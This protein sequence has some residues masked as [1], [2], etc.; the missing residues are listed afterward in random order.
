MN[1]T[2]ALLMCLIL[3]VAVRDAQCD[4]ILSTVNGV[5]FPENAGVVPLG[6]YAHQNTATPTTLSIGGFISIEAGSPGAFVDDTPLNL[7][8]QDVFTWSAG[9]YQSNVVA[10]GTPSQVTVPPL[11]AAFGLEFNSPQNFSTGLANRDLLGHF[12][13]NINGM[14]PGI[15]TVRVFDQFSD[16]PITSTNGTFEIIAVAVPEPG[17]LTFL[18]AAVSSLAFR[19]ARR[20][21]SSHQ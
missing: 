15:Y 18:V 17:S 11:E 19:R 20:F 3:A 12:N 21:T 1:K 14:S 4:L 2:I 16:V 8:D 10:S 7:F 13:F 5:T 9:V 6:I